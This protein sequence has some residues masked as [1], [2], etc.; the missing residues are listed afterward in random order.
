MQSLTIATIVKPKPTTKPMIKLNKM[1]KYKGF[2]DQWIQ[3]ANII[4]RVFDSTKGFVVEAKD[5]I[6]KK[7]FSISEYNGL[8]YSLKY[9]KSCRSAL[10]SF[11]STAPVN[12][13]GIAL[14]WDGIPTFFEDLI[15]II[16]KRD[17]NTI[18]AVLS[19]LTLGRLYTDVG[20]LVTSQITSKSDY[21]IS[22]TQEEIETFVKSNNLF[23]NEVDEPEL[24]IRSSTGPAGPAMSSIIQEAKNLPEVLV[25]D[26]RKVLPPKIMEELDFCRTESCYSIPSFNVNLDNKSYRKLTVVEDKECKNRVIAIFDY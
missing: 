7:L 21:V 25:E 13:T 22:I 6:F 20:E 1:N 14:T 10:Y 16:R 9:M 26:L 15:P 8:A 5:I 2:K 12:V 17:K 18:R 24:Y 19:L 23:I 11:A 4:V 3:G